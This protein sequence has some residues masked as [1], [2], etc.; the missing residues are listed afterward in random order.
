MGES[1]FL[2]VLGLILGSFLGALTYRLPR[3][4]SINEGRSKCPNCGKQI[5]WYDNIP[6]LSFILLQGKCRSCGEKIS[7]RYPLIEALTAVV[8]VSIG[9]HIFPLIL[10][11][12]LIAIFVTDIENQLIFDELV[13][14]GLFFVILNLIVLNSDQLFVYLLGGFLASI[15]LLI[16]NFLTNGRG[17]GLGDVKLAIL[18]G[19]L[20]PIELILVWFFFSFVSGAVVGV[21]LIMVRNAKLKQKIAFG[22]FLIIGL[23]LTLFFGQFFLKGVIGL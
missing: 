23:V 10:A 2:S 22:P 5:E 19:S 6:L 20:L 3:K 21:I 16:I 13:F 1:V 7:F 4:L 18:L 15:L 12:I 9:L 8:F 11:S 14:L 17:M